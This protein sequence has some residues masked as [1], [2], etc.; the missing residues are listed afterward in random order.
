MP[1][2]ERCVCRD[3]RERHR[4]DG[5][6]EIRN[7][8]LSS[9]GVLDAHGDGKE[10]DQRIAAARP[11]VVAGERRNNERACDEEELRLCRD[12]EVA[13]AVGRRPRAD[14]AAN[15]AADEERA[16]RR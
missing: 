9:G 7:R 8:E 5:R 10:H 13:G 6:G 4:Q 15:Q 1:A 16:E 3:T 11:E 14:T 12:G 2:G